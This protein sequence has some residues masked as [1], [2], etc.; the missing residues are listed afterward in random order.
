M[1]PKNRDLLGELCRRQILV[2][3]PI[4]R[5][6]DPDFAVFIRRVYGPDQLATWEQAMRGE[7]GVSSWNL[8]LGF[9]VLVG[10]GLSFR[11]YETSGPIIASVSGAIN[12]LVTVKDQLLGGLRNQSQAAK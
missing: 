4:L 5:F 3:K 2:M 11:G 6:R 9:F 1:N 7:T 8:L 12:L 10:I